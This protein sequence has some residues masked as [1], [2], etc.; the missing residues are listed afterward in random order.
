MATESNLQQSSPGV[1]TYRGRTLEEILPQ[2]RAELGADAIIL[3]EREG[4]VGG[5]GGFFAQRF[6]EVD[7]RRGEG[8]SI[9]VYDDEPE[10]DLR[11]DATID[12]EP[13]I[14]ERKAILPPEP[15]DI[16]TK[17]ELVPERIDRSQPRLFVPPAVNVDRGTPELAPNGRRFETGVFME[18]LREASATAEVAEDPSPA[19][20]RRPR[21][22]AEQTEKPKPARKPRAPRSG[23]Q[24]PAKQP[25]RSPQGQRELS[26]SESWAA[27]MAGMPLAELAEDTAATEAAAATA[28]HAAA[29]AD[30]PQPVTLPPAR[31]A[32]PTSPPSVRS[33]P[34]S[35]RAARKP[36]RAVTKPPARRPAK[37]AKPNRNPAPEPP[38]AEPMPISPVQEMAPNPKILIPQR[39]QSLRPK[40]PLNPAITGLAGNGSAPP[41]GSFAPAI[42]PKRAV[43]K[44]R[45]HDG[46]GLRG[47]LTRLL[48]GG[49][50]SP[51]VKP[52]PAKPIDVVAATEVAQNLST[53]GASQAWTSQLITAASAHGSPLAGSL[54]EATEAEVARRIMPAPAL[55]V[56]GAAVAFIGAGGSGKTR[57]TAALASAYRRS[58]TLSVSVIALDNPEGAR[59]LRRLLADDDV[60]VMSFSGA[61]AKRAVEEGR[62]GGLVIIDTLAATPTDPA[63]VEAL[64]LTLAPLELDA[65]YVAL[66][67]TLGPQA[68]RRAL[69]SFGTLKPAA[70]AITHADETDQLAVAIEIAVAHRIPLAYFH[71]GTDH[72]SAL[73]AVDPPALAQQLLPS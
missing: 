59:E 73:S 32:E 56:T 30:A 34:I 48:G 51:I 72:R 47:T 6:I 17:R 63:A 52:A 39:P 65:T 64:G 16:G 36:P 5:V 57:C 43:A 46:D 55:P 53:R 62:D 50:R 68:A 66:P 25:S 33:R 44:T 71:S 15:T 20:N 10:Y 69:A 35:P 67:A 12:P 45:P 26:K 27:E 24:A 22:Q 13:V 40:T 60:P 70:V 28:A 29:A 2:I 58:S 3:R 21:I 54:R 11:N 38:A 41:N 42:V 49:R 4:L 31:S 18:R 23:P 7:A 9:D 61:M 8:Q 14:A 37:P 1:R 19:T